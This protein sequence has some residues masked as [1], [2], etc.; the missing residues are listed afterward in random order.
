LYAFLQPTLDQDLG[1]EQCIEHLPDQEFVPQ[2]S[3]E[4]FNIAV[5][6]W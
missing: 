2:L 4:A 3:I 6:S 1:L 5:L